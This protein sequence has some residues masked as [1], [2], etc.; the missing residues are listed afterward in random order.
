AALPE[1]GRMLVLPLSGLLASLEQ[2]ASLLARAPAAAIPVP[3]FPA[4]AGPAYYLGLAG[5]IAAARSEGGRRAAA[6]TIAILGPVLVGGGELALAAGGGPSVAVHDVGDGQA[7]LL[8]G[9]G[10]PVL[11]D[12]GG[13]PTRLDAELGA[14]LPPWQR[15]L[16]ALVITAPGAP[17]VGGL[18]TLGRPA[19]QVL[20]PAA[21]L[22]GSAWRSVA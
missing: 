22:S 8:Q 9:P 19:R 18:A 13:S 1:L 20:L 10:G 5:T 21:P 6:L 11:V 12:G 17:H 7:V 16:E 3:S 4:W 14:R 2:V 15:D